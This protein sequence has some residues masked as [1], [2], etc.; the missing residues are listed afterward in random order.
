[1]AGASFDIFLQDVRYAVRSLRRTPSFTLAVVVT[2][3]L[4]LGANTAIF[5]LLDAVMFKPL[6]LPAP[7]ELV[8]LFETRPRPSP[9][10]RAEW[11]DTCASRTRGSSASNTRSEAP[12]P[13]RR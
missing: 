1:M 7:H 3:A 6:P 4:G 5:T 12:A 13:S 11:D 8:T 9:M 10:S 2:L